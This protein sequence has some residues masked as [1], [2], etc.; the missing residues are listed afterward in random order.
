M[1]Y[2]TADSMQRFE[3]MAVDMRE[4]KDSLVK[5]A[6]EFLQNAPAGVER[7]PEKLSYMLS[8]DLRDTLP[9]QIFALIADV[10]N[11]LKK[12]LEE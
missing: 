12:S 2:R 11:E 3:R 4:N 6:K 8:T 5:F 1:I 10:A 7:D 9:P